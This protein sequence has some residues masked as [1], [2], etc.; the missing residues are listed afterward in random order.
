MERSTS[1]EIDSRSDSQEI[2][3]RSDSQEIPR[4]LWNPKFHYCIRLI[5]CNF[6]CGLIMCV[7]MLCEGLIHVKK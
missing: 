4:L 6:V 1:S 3:S 2:D 7:Q 5:V